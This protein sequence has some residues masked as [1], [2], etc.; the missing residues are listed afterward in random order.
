MKK[1]DIR[2]NMMLELVEFVGPE[3]WK[4]LDVDF[5]IL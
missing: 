2:K 3:V 4:T 5:S 1:N